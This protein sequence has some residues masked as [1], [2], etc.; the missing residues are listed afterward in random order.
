MGDTFHQTAIAQEH[1][2]VV[3]DDSMPVTI[4][5]GSQR[6]LG[7]GHPHSIGKTLTKRPRGGLHTRGVTV[8]RVP[9]C[10]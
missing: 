7:D 1:V 2:G 10:L 6:F 8:L 5:L 9:G 3:V 4:E